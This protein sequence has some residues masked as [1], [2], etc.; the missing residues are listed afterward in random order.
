M[1]TMKQNRRIASAF[2]PHRGRGSIKTRSDTLDRVAETRILASQV[3]HFIFASFW[4][5]TRLQRMQRGISNYASRYFCLAW[6]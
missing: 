6:V 2:H 1:V 3:F 5:G 4:P